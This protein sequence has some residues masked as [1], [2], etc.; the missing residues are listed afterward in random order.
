MKTLVFCL[1][2]MLLD[3]VSPIGCDDDNRSTNSNTPTQSETVDNAATQSEAPSS[4]PISPV[5]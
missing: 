4:T 5:K 3:V 2:F 1:G